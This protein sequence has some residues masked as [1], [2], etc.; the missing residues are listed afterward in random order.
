MAQKLTTDEK[1]LNAFSKL[2]EENGYTETTTKKIAQ[3]AG[4]NEST[5][6]RHFKDKEQLVK[7]L[8][9]KYMSDIDTANAGFIASGDIVSDLMQVAEIYN[10]FV[11]THKA[12]FLIGMRDSFQFPKLKEMIIQLPMKLKK[13]LIS[14][15]TEMKRSGEINELVNVDITAANYIT[16]ILGHALIQNIYTGTGLDISQTDFVQKNVRNFAEYLK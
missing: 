6:F 7:E 16:L 14:R 11:E 10:Q 5:L 2:L 8:V 15:M 9:Q 4:V 13:I 1:I 12:L 3:A